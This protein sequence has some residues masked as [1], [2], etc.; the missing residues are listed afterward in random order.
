MHL[1]HKIP[2]NT[3]STHFS[4]IKCNR[5]FTPHRTDLFSRNKPSEPADLRHFR[6]VFIATIREFSTTEQTKPL[7][8]IFPHNLISDTLISYPERKYG[9]RP[10]ATN[11]ALHNPLSSKHKNIQYWID[12]A[13]TE[14]PTYTSS[15][16]DLSDAAKMLIIIAASAGSKD[17]E[18]KEMSREAV[19]VLFAL[20]RHPQVPVHTLAGIHWGHA[21]GVEL[22]AD[23]A[24]EAYLLINLVDG[25]FSRD[26]LNHGISVGKEVS[27]L[28]MD[29]FRYFASNALQDYDYPTQNI[30]HRDFWNKLGVTDNWAHQQKFRDWKGEGQDVHA[31]NP[32]AAGNEEATQDLEQY[33]KTCFAILYVYDM[34]LRELHGENEADAKWG[35]WIDTFFRFCGSEGKY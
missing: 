6:H 19:S 26:R 31:I 14:E 17:T 30:P 32:L 18:A 20:S 28:E 1:D 9:L 4:L 15:D 22:V 5:R 21:F 35:H 16:G 23:F 33:L 11:S 13:V 8:P 34:L 3:A 27:L 2:W 24:L 12:R 25:V 7:S 29:R 10:H